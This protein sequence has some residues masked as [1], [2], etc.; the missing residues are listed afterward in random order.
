MPLNIAALW[1]V[2]AASV[3]FAIRA[4]TQIT[5]IS[6]IGVAEG[7]SGTVTV[8]GPR[9]PAAVV[10]RAVAGSLAGV[11]LAFAAC[12][13]I[14][15]PAHT[16]SEFHVYRATSRQHTLQVKVPAGVRGYQTARVQSMLRDT[17]SQLPVFGKTPTLTI[18]AANLSSG[19]AVSS[20]NPEFLWS[21]KADAGTYTVMLTYPEPLLESSVVTGVRLPGDDALTDPEDLATVTSS[22]LLAPMQVFNAVGVSVELQ[23][24]VAGVMAAAGLLVSALGL[25]RSR[26]TDEEP[27]GHERSAAEP[28]G[29]DDSVPRAVTVAPIRRRRRRRRNKP[30]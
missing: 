17:Y 27:A 20:E 16:G 25:R 18:P 23:T 28:P 29:D 11:V 26:A 4:F 5:V 1:A 13:L 14:G 10:W 12:W 24:A 15:E 30:R 6:F 21:V 7:G 8:V 2:G 9:P 19:M 3:P 22:G